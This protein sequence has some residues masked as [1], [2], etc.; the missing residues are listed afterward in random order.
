MYFNR[1]HR[2]YPDL[3]SKRNTA[4]VNIVDHPTEGDTD[5]N[6]EVTFPS[7]FPAGEIQDETNTGPEFDQFKMPRS[8]ELGEELT[9]L[10]TERET[11][12]LNQKLTEPGRMSDS[13]HDDNQFEDADMKLG[14]VEDPDSLEEPV[15]EPYT[16]GTGPLESR[17][18]DTNKKNIITHAQRQL[19]AGK[20]DNL[21]K[22]ANDEIKLQEDYKGINIDIEWPKGSIRSYKGNDTYVTLMKCD[23]GYAHGIEGS[24]GE[25]L[26]I[27]LGDADSD[28]AYIIEQLKADGS[29]DED[30]IMLGFKS[31]SDAVDMYLSHM[32]SYMLGDTR[33]VSVDKLRNA[34]Y[35]KPEDR[36]GGNDL[37]PNEELNKEAQ[38]DYS[39]PASAIRSV[40]PD[41]DGFLYR[42]GDINSGITY[43]H[44]SFEGSEYYLGESSHDD[45]P[46][47]K[48]YKCPKSGKTFL[49]NVED[50]EYVDS[51]LTKEFGKPF[52]NEDYDTNYDDYPSAIELLMLRFVK[53][54]YDWVIINGEMFD[55]PGYPVEAVKLKNILIQEIKIEKMDDENFESNEGIIKTG[56]GQLF[57]KEYLKA[58]S[59]EWVDKLPGGLADD[60]IP[61]DF[62]SELILEGLKVE[63]EHTDDILVALEI[64]MDHLTEDEEYYKKLLKMEATKTWPEDDIFENEYTDGTEDREDRD[65]PRSVEKEQMTYK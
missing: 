12:K 20:K 48:K 19:I 54:G 18:E 57:T 52:L 29:Y 60:K 63:L 1:L 36:R 33:E 16:Q 65:I 5:G 27:Y 55:Q 46:V 39:D 32:P 45:S 30:K 38:I 64:T 14:E 50:V 25:E 40:Y 8:A 22:L 28:I 56:R 42:V 17:Y 41:W 51:L 44:T 15:Y 23:Y 21:K 7:E 24:D 13:Y 47:V 9:Q 3:L 11:S 58:K 34:L 61:S 6:L 49:F 10:T 31:E 4:A 43:F 37:I 59:N 62:D 2:L 35:D 53:F 26:D